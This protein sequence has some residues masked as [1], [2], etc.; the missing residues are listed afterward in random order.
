MT[1]NGNRYKF[2]KIC[3]EKFVKLHQV[4][5]LFLA[6]FCYLEPQCDSRRKIFNVSLVVAEHRDLEGWCIFFFKS[7]TLIVCYM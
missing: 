3:I 1:G 4:E 7:L 6:G 2:A 5:N